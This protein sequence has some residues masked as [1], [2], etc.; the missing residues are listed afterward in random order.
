MT[1]ATT[2]VTGGTGFLGSHVVH[3]LLERGEEVRVLARSGST[4]P[5][6]AGLDVNRRSGSVL[7]RATVRRALKGTRLLVHAAGLVSFRAADR[8]AL[9]EVNVEGTRVV[10]EE[11]LRAGVE[12]AVLISSAATVGPATRSKTVDE[13]NLFRAGALGIPYVNAKREAEI[14]ALRVAASGLDL[15]C[16]NPSVA[17]GPGDES[18]RATAIVPAFL[19]GHIPAYVDG[20]LNIVDVRDVAKAVVVAAERGRTAERYILGGR[21]FTL[22]RLFADLARLAGIEPPVKLPAGPVLAAVRAAEV[23]GIRTGLHFDQVKASAQRW[24]YRSD[25]AKR[26][27]DFQPRPHEETLMDTVAWHLEKLGAPPTA[28]R[29]PSL[30]L[31]AAGFAASTLEGLRRG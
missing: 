16:V 20:T 9:F 31:R 12:R 27:L 3:A 17:L 22:D 2:V 28:S 18:S 7:D 30:P 8:K 25:K 24:A 6:L 1:P 11:A 13:Q 14:E 19:R 10:M 5:S 23:A 21:N 4:A 15:V 29:G 26:E